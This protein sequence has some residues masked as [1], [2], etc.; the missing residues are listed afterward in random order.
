[1]GLNL[2]RGLLPARRTE[3][4]DQHT[5]AP[6]KETLTPHETGILE[7]LEQPIYS[8][9][10]QLKEQIN[11]GEYSVILGDDASGRLPALMVWQ[12]VKELYKR[13][14][15]PAPAIRFVAGER[16]AMVEAQHKKQQVLQNYFGKMHDDI[17]REHAK[18][19][20][21]LIVTDTIAT[22][23]TIDIFVKALRQNDWPMDV[24]TLS[25]L[26]IGT[27]QFQ[28]RWNTTVVTGTNEKKK[29]YIDGYRNDMKGVEKSSKQLFVHPLTRLDAERHKEMRATVRLA[30]LKTKEI[31]DR[32]LR[33]YPK[34]ITP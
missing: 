21:V 14:G 25:T 4:H 8:I 28:N 19:G 9:V 32:I 10:T 1:M 17:S 27:S 13:K 3:N 12:V 11:R 29:Y 24:A 34:D 22:G 23:H 16:Y 6:E 26:Y 20:K 33:N 30:R 15:Y 2:F 31:S 7:E 5:S 18:L